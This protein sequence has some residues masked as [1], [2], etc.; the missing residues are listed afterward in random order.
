MF[1]LSSYLPSDEDPS[2][3]YYFIYSGS[4]ISYPTIFALFFGTW[5]GIRTIH[6]EL[7]IGNSLIIGII[8]GMIQG[9]LSTSIY[10]FD[11]NRNVGSQL[12]GSEEPLKYF[13]QNFIN[14][15]FFI[16]ILTS[17]T[18]MIVAAIIQEIESSKKILAE[19]YPQPRLSTKK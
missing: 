16:A 13:S 10:V 14:Y 2:V 3:F 7:K 15:W 18:S 9:F 5:V 6:F 19:L 17:T 1:F 8:V 12:F 11:F 4:E